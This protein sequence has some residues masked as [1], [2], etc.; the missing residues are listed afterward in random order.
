M[1]VIFENIFILIVVLV[2][3]AT[4]L[5]FGVFCVGTLMHFLRGRR[6]RPARRR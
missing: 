4:G 3:L 6:G 2:G 5:A 1:V